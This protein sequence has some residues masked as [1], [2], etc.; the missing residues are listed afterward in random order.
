MSELNFVLRGKKVHWHAAWRY[1]VF[2]PLRIPP[3]RKGTFLPP[4]TPLS[5]SR[6]ACWRKKQVPRYFEWVKMD[7]IASLP[8]T[9]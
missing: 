8:A 2:T 6:T 4:D 7:G 3:K 1:G 9:K 5:I